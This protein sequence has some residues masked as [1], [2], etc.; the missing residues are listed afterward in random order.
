M[1]RQ[2]LL[3]TIVLLMTGAIVDGKPSLH[4]S[5]QRS[6]Y[7]S[8]GGFDGGALSA[9]SYDS[10]GIQPSHHRSSRNNQK[11]YWWQGPESPF[12]EGAAQSHGV[13]SGSPKGPSRPQTVIGCSGDGCS[14]PLF[15]APVTSASVAS[16][17]SSASWGSSSGSFN[18]GGGGGGG[19][20]CSGGC[21]YF[22]QKPGHPCSNHAGP[23]CPNGFSCVHYEW[24]SN[25]IVLRGGSGSSSSPGHKPSRHELMSHGKPCGDGTSQVCCMVEQRPAERPQTQPVISSPS[26][27]SPSYPSP[28]Y[29]SPSYPSPSYP[30]PSYPS[31][32]YPSAAPAFPAFTYPPPETTPR[33]T[34][35]RPVTQPVIV[36][37]TSYLPPTQK[38]VTQPVVAPDTSY[39]PPILPPVQPPVKQPVVENLVQQTTSVYYPPSPPVVV[40]TQR[41]RPVV[42]TTTTRRPIPPTQPVVAAAP[43]GPPGNE[44]PYPGCAAALKCV[45]EEFCSIEGIMVNTPVFL[46]EQQKI[47]RVPLMS[48]FNTETG[49]TGY[50]CRDPLYQDPWPGGM[51]MPAAPAPPPPPPVAPVVQEPVFVGC[52]PDEMCLNAQVC[53]MKLGTFN[54]QSGPCQ[55]FNG[56]GGVCCRIPVP[57]APT[58]EYLPPPPVTTTTTTTTPRPTQPVVAQPPPPPPPIDYLP[59]VPATTTTRRPPVTQ[60]VVVPSQEYLPPV[61][62]PQQPVTSYVPP[63]VQPTPNRPAPPPVPAAQ[64]AGEQCGVSRPMAQAVATGEAAL[65]EFPWHAMIAQRNGSMSCS[66]ALIGPKFVA[67]AFHCVRGVPPSSLRVRLGEQRVGASNEPLPHYEIPVAAVIGHPQFVDG[68]LFNDVAVLMLAAA[69]PD[70]QDHIAPICLPASSEP[71][72]TQCVVTGWGHDTLSG[73][74]EGTLN[75]VRVDLVRN[76]DCQGSLQ[77]THLGKYFKLHQSFTCASTLNSIN[78]CKVDGGS[79]LACKR[80]DGG[81]V[82]AG[83]SSWSV[84]CSNQHQPGVYVDVPPVA[85]WMQEQMVQPEPVLVEQS[86]SEFQSQQQ[87]QGEFGAS[88]GY[89][90]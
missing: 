33:P 76:S 20:G 86:N 68:S 78:P 40:T 2:I 38:P 31:P 13:S 82:L 17:P 74:Q 57:A 24:C 66:G 28:S 47:F 49:Q 14:S 64:V 21:Q 30:S 32:S 26:Y 8:F 25:G 77:N 39:L 90:R 3:L 11:A 9:S 80:P 41:P 36:P 55:T 70:G 15:Q 65:G 88:A 7:G 85:Q 22:W 12:N 1:D 42:T 63:A 37:D 44:I 59:P 50:C 10:L 5:R 71:L 83:L 35:Q 75:K 87:F 60:P 54:S 61:S 27:P 23:G 43:Q 34:T 16:A 45:T 29:P 69:A 84:G 48:C 46:T 53:S 67:T 79:P 4:R 19:G 58:Q 56:Q 6:A 81:H 89:G 62:P 18:S 52:S 73:L 51:P 72:L